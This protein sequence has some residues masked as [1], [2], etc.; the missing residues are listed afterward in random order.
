MD[1]RNTAFEDRAVPEEFVDRLG[2]SRLTWR[3]DDVGAF[4]GLDFGPVRDL[5]DSAD[6]ILDSCPG[7]ALLFRLVAIAVCMLVGIQIILLA[8]SHLNLPL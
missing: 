7:A 4:G 1:V 2:I 3:S 6:D 5:Y 8:C